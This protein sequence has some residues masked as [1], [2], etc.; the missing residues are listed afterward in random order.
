MCTSLYA[1]AGLPYPASDPEDPDD[2]TRPATAPRPPAHIPAGNSDS[3]AL[4]PFVNVQPQPVRE[5]EAADADARRRD[6][7]WRRHME[8]AESRRRAEEEDWRRRAEDEDGR[9]R[10]DEVDGRRRA[11]EVEGRRRA[12]EEDARRRAEEDWRRRRWEEDRRR[13]ADGQ[14]RRRSPARPAW[15]WGAVG[16]VRPGEQRRPQSPVRSPRRPVPAAPGPAR[17]GTP[18]TS[19]IICLQGGGTYQWAVYGCV[20][21]RLQMRTVWIPNV[22]MG[23]F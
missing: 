21:L 15:T 7:A 8:E 23:E 13:E 11:E 6:E 10:A 3:P 17:A 4:K 18:G 1:G 12:E 9:R 2:P 22:A 19:W 16:A 14:R 20:R 5:T